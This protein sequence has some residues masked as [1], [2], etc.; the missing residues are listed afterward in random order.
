MKGIS[1]PIYICKNCGNLTET[2]ETHNLFC[3]NCGASLDE[4]KPQEEP[5]PQTESTQ[6]PTRDTPSE[7]KPAEAPDPSEDDAEPPVLEEMSPEPAGS[8]QKPGEQPESEQKDLQQAPIELPETKDSPPSSPPAIAGAP[9]TQSHTL[10][11]QTHELMEVYENKNLVA[12]PQ[13]GY[14]CDPSWTDCPICKAKISGAV[15]LQKVSESDFT[16]SEEKLKEKLVP[17]PKCN[18]FCDPN[19]DKCPI[20][21]A[22]IKKAEK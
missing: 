5:A 16:I 18:Y 20:C 21:K 17:C 7:H 9:S 2:E 19:W 6:P 8:A 3:S 12:C 22:E 11:G 4:S 14:G 10:V 15:D 13:C 1:V